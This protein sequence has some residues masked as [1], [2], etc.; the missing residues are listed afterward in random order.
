MEQ[1]LK[2]YFKERNWAMEHYKELQEKY[3]DQWVAVKSNKVVLHGK[4]VE[5]AQDAFT[6]FITSGAEVFFV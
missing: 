2:E 4:A 5:N 1:K 3:P 6:I